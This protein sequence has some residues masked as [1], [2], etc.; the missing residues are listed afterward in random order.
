MTDA[1]GKEIKEGSTVV[2]G[3]GTGGSTYHL[4]EVIRLF[5][6]KDA[7]EYS[8]DVGFGFSPAKVEIKVSRSTHG[9]KVANLVL[10]AKNV[11][12]I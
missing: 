11:V 1:F 8:P 10:Y 12:V 5:P 3:G 9:M 4:G 7:S 6:E 2:Y